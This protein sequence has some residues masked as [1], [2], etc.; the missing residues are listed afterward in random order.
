MIN[1]NSKHTN[2]LTTGTPSTWRNNIQAKSANFAV[3][4]FPGNTVYAQT[5]QADIVVA[6]ATIETRLGAISDL[7]Q[8]QVSTK[9]P[10][11]YEPTNFFADSWRRG[12]CRTREQPFR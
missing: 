8:S 10:L 4:V 9:K 2:F 11:T 12:I 5:F 1:G 3:L 6:Y 7:P